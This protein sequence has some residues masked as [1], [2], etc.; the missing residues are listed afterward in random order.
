MKTRIVVA[1]LVLI[2]TAGIIGGVL[3]AEAD[4][5]DAKAK[6]KLVIKCPV[7]GKSVDSMGGKVAVDFE[8]G[9]V[10][11]CCDMC[12]PTFK[13]DTAKYAAKRICRWSRPI[14]SNKS[15]ARSPASH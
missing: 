11:F 2:A 14:S 12:P 5:S 9:K 15:L 1:L 10:Y 8:G 4:K 3:A 13:K 7:T 6:E